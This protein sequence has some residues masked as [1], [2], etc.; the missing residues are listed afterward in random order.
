M[1]IQCPTNGYSPCF[2]QSDFAVAFLDTTFSHTFAYGYGDSLPSTETVY[3][4]GAHAGS[5]C[6]QLLRVLLQQKGSVLTLHAGCRVPRCGALTCSRTLRAELGAWL[7]AL[8]LDRLHACYLMCTTCCAVRP[9][10]RCGL[11]RG[12]VCN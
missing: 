9:E 4:A 5:V 11:R 8:S 6:T 12:Q 3:T 1:V 7:A 2:A 10:V